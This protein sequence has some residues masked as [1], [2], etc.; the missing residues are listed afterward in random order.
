MNFSIWVLKTYKTLRRTV[1][2]IAILLLAIWYFNPQGFSGM[3][4][5]GGDL[6]AITGNTIIEIFK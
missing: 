1:L 2:I 3:V 4:S 6:A 5:A